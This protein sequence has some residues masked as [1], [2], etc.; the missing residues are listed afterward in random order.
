MG[1]PATNKGDDLGFALRSTNNGEMRVGWSAV[2]N[3]GN[4]V[5]W[6]GGFGLYPLVLYLLYT[7]RYQAAA[8]LVAVM[9]FMFNVDLGTQQS[10]ADFFYSGSMYMSRNSSINFED[11]SF[12]AKGAKPTFLAVHPHGCFSLGYRLATVCPEWASSANPITKVVASTLM[13]QPIASFIFRHQAGG[14]YPADKQ[15]F[16][17]A[18]KSGKH[19]AFLPGGFPEATISS[20]VA[21][22]VW[23]ASSGFVYYALKYGYSITPVYCFGEK[24]GY[25]NIQGFWKQRVKLALKGI[26]TI[27]CFGQ[28]WAPWLPL[29][30]G[31][32]EGVHVVHGSPIACPELQEPG[33]PTK[34]EV[35]AFRQRY[36]VALCDLYYRNAPKFYKEGTYEPELEVWSRDCPDSK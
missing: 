23:T 2:T 33:K 15:S 8:T 29:T 34:E 13:M 18:M 14:C 16:Q 30:L 27:A 21:D 31:E 25:H 24:C 3:T 26:P 6:A 11:T 1:N 17:T 28:W 20:R 10:I 5:V 35:E 19:I 9:V 36:E 4:M 12:L 7:G 22:R 32:D